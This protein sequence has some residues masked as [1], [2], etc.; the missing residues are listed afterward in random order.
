LLGILAST[1]QTWT[2][3]RRWF[4]IGLVM[5]A[6][7]SGTAPSAGPTT[8]SI[9]VV[10]VLASDAPRVALVERF[11]VAFNAGDEKT[12]LALF[13]DA[14]VVSDCDYAKV[15]VV[16]F[17]GR[18]EVTAWLAARFADH[19]QLVP[20]VVSNENPDPA[21]SA[22][23][24]EFARRTNDTLRRLGFPHGVKPQLATKIRFTGSGEGLRIE[25]FANGPGGGPAS[26]CKPS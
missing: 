16:E 26:D 9:S 8:V 2:V 12:V 7:S 6:C 23:G 11:L 5:A 21:S 20:T 3:V 22:I 25:T 10:T 13:N 18:S 19:D 17:R 24:V 15:S 4:S 14:P 1:R